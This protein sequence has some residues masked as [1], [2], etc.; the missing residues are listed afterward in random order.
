[1]RY[2]IMKQKNTKRILA[3]AALSAIGLLAYQPP[4]QAQKTNQPATSQASEDEPSMLVKSLSFRGIEGIA[5]S[6][7]LEKQ[8]PELA[9]TEATLPQLKDAAAQITRYLRQQG[10]IVATAYIP[11]QDFSTGHVDIAVAVGHYDEVKLANH[12]DIPDAVI[13]RELGTKVKSGEIIQQQNLERGILLVNDLADVEASSLLMAG[14]QSGTS[15]LLITVNPKNH[16]VSGYLGVDNGGYSNTGRYRY[17][18]LVNGAN[19]LK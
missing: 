14:S 19:P 1:M 5:T 6:Q 13:L 16:P 3:I 11:P 9:G 4:I 7:E 12:T 15:S 2:L 10:Y 8:L 18:A 17:S